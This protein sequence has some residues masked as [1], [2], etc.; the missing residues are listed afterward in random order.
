[1]I[2]YLIQK[3]NSSKKPDSVA[4]CF[5]FMVLEKAILLQRET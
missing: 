5:A 4:H 1:M 3:S 2:T